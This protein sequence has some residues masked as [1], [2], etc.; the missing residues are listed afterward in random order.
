LEAD[1]IISIPKIETHH[2]AGVSLS[3][4]NMFGVVLR[5]KYGWPK[6]ILHWRRIYNSI[7]DICATVPIHLVIADGIQAMEGN[8]PLHGHC[9]GLR[10]S[11]FLQ[12]SRS[13]RVA[14]I[15]PSW[16]T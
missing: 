1:F 6:N 3:M 14:P 8:G 2:W 10:K 9:P 12:L 11:L 4:K 7:V 15:W 5:L 16:G 13:R